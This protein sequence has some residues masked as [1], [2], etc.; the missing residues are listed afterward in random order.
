MKTSRKWI[1]Y[2][3][4]NK[5]R[6]RVNWLQPPRIR[7]SE[8]ATVLRSLQAWQLGETSDGAH[9]L[10][11]AGRYA[12]RIGDTDY[13]EAVKLFIQEEQKHGANLG[14]YLDLIGKPRIRS[15]W[16]DTLFRKVRYFNTSM[17]IWTL[18]VITV[19]SAA[20]IFYQAL[21]NATGCPLLKEICTDILCDEGPHLVFQTE[22]LGILFSE[23]S[24][25]GKWFRRF[26]YAVFFS[27][28]SLLVWLAH[29]KLFRAG[30]V[31][32]E[33]YALKMGQQYFNRIYRTTFAESRHPVSIPKD[34]PAVWNEV[35]S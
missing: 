11:A 10:R 23:K 18:A 21:K 8:L 17:E 13:I 32:F 28:T 5:T 35:Q 7:E 27:G 19:E 9:L 3:L 31:N 29:R 24:F 4:V 14:R 2:F 34:V 30:G 22:R 1:D 12:R 15:D 6:V 16:G 26:A 33:R 20:Q 25:L